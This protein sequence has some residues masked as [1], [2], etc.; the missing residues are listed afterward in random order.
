M[1]INGPQ[2]P[3]KQ[4]DL[5]DLLGD[6]H[7]ISR[8]EDEHNRHQEY[9]TQS[10]Y[11]SLNNFIITYTQMIHPSSHS[12]CSGRALVSAELYIE[13]KVSANTSLISPGYETNVLSVLGGA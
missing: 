6:L 4:K 13:P 10:T 8:L 9:L 5:E 11:I 2:L 1:Y 12:F 7:M 3:L